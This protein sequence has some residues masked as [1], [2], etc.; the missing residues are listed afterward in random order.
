MQPAVNVVEKLLLVLPPEKERR[1]RSAELMDH[2]SVPHGERIDVYV[3]EPGAPRGI[4][5]N[6]EDG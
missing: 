3:S 1:R 2:R 5:T 6:A 4:A